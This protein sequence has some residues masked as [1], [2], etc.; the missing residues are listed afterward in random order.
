MIWQHREVPFN[1]QIL[2]SLTSMQTE[3]PMVTR[4]IEK[5]EE[6]KEKKAVMKEDSSKNATINTY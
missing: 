1:V 4:N 5:K 2:H 6:E 3:M